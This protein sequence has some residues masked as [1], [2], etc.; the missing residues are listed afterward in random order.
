MKT[1][2]IDQLNQYFKQNAKTKHKIVG[3]QTWHLNLN[4]LAMSQLAFS[5][6]GKI[7]DMDLEYHV[8]DTPRCSQWLPAYTG[9]T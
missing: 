3:I 7:T 4:P 5:K 6:G 9:K 2:P 1:R 8:V